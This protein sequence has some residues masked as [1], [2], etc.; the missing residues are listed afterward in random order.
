MRVAFLSLPVPGHLNPMTALARKYQARGHEVVFLSL[1]DVAPFVQAAQLPFVPCAED[2]YPPGSLGKYLPQ[3]SRLSGTEALSYTVNEMMKG[4]TESLFQ[5]LPETLRKAGADAI[6]LDQY[7]PYVELIPKCLGMP[8]VHVSNALHVDYT[9]RS[10]LCFYGRRPT[11]SDETARN[12]E[13]VERFRVL[14][15]PTTAMAR[16][17]ARKAGIYVDW[18]NPDSTVSPLLWVTQTPREFDFDG[19]PHLPQFHYSGPWHDGH[20]RIPVEFPWERLTGEPIVYVS[21]GT[22]QNGVTETFRAIAASARRLKNLQFVLAIGN[23]IT[24]EE[25]GETASNILTVAHAPQIELLKRSSLCITHAGLNT[26]LEA[27]G[28]GVPLLAVPI[29]NDQPGVAARIAHK[30]VGLVISQDNLSSSDLPALITQAVEDS[31]IRANAR[32]LSEAI[33]K[34]D[35]LAVAA[36]LIEKAL[37]LRSTHPRSPRAA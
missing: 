15:E 20:G 3:L 37:G 16:Q 17:Y 25:I 1:P 5:S 22:L 10:P 2:A 26:V 35:G 7:Q 14:L 9:G 36:E 4:Y 32:R 24:P 28:C 29:T 27:L 34:T 12:R 33:S 23:Q 13:D 31:R 6:V 18:K 11:E 30:E 19:A 8:Y 21:M